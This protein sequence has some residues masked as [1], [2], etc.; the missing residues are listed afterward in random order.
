MPTLRSANVRS[1]K[2]SVELEFIS[3][4]TD[5]SFFLRASCHLPATWDHLATSFASGMGPPPLPVMG[6]P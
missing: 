4:T 1:V 3:L 5:M 2:G 6:P